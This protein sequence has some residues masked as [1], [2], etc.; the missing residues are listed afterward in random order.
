MFNGKNSH[1]IRVKRAGQTLSYMTRVVNTHGVVD[2]CG[3]AAE[4]KPDG[5]GVLM[6]DINTISVSAAA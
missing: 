5:D 6:V 4:V 3:Y 1:L 2:V